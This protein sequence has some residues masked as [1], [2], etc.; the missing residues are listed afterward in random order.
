MNRD[1]GNMILFDDEQ[2][3]IIGN[4][5]NKEIDILANLLYFSIDKTIAE[6]EKGEEDKIE[7]K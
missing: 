4:M 7:K 2:K 1:Y 3:K 5:S 6:L